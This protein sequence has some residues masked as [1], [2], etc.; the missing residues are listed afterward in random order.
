MTFL[1]S[2][3]SPLA[4]LVPLIIVI[5][6]AM[7]KQGYEDFLRYRADSMVN[8]SMVKVI[9]NG[10]EVEIKCEDIIPGDLVRVARDCD[11]PC[12]LLL[13]KSSDNGK[14]FITTANLDGETNLKTLVVPKGLPEL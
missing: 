13:M 5:S 10:V 2:P 12:D 7:F 9:R 11:I 1:D 4:S 14:C 3:V 6:V 8:K